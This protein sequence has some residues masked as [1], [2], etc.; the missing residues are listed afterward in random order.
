[1]SDISADHGIPPELRRLDRDQ[2]RSSFTN[3]GRARMAAGN[4]AIVSLLFIH[5]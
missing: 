5:M 2:L 3:P 1:L 4:G